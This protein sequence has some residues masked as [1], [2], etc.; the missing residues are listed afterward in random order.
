M[1]APSSRPWADKP[2]EL[3]PS[4]TL[5][6]KPGEKVAPIHETAEEMIIIHNVLL[7]GINS[8][9]LQ[10]VNVQKAPKPAKGPSVT[11][12][13]TH[14]ALQWGETIEEHHHIEETIL[15]PGMAE[16]VGEPELMAAEV[17]QH[18]A[19][20]D[21]LDGYIAYLKAV[22]AKEQEYDGLKLRGIIDAFMPILRQHL[23]DEIVT[24]KGLERF[25]GEKREKLIKTA[26]KLAAQIKEDAQKKSETKVCGP[27]RTWRVRKHC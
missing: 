5:G 21:G 12:N 15:F 7:R 14:Y 17:G 2:F 19:F 3:I 16:A 25:E 26:K 4:S 6:Y 11:E 27:L 22:I 23:M 8:I 1:P 24:L 20:H 13:F 18:K 9:Y 10:C